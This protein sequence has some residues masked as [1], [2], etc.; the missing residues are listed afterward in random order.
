MRPYPP[1]DNNINKAA[2][3]I[4]SGGIV[5]FP[6]E[7]V[8][9]LGANALNATAVVKIFEAKERPFFDPLI[10]HIAEKDV[11]TELITELDPLSEQL[12]DTFW[13]G[14]LTLVF[15]KNDIVPDITTSGLETVAVRMPKNDVAISL[16]KASHS[17]IAAPSANKFSALSPTNAEHVIFQLGNKV[18]MVLDGG[19]CKVGVESTILKVNNGIIYLLRPGG[20]SV[21]EIEAKTN[22]KVES[23]IAENNDKT[24]V[25][26]QLPFHYSPSTPIKILDTN[27]ID[28][29]NKNVVYLLFTDTLPTIPTEKKA[30]LSPTGNLQEA[31]ANLFSHL[32]M[33]DKKNA[34][35]IIAEPVPEEGLGR[36]IMDRLHKATKKHSN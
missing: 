12:I 34:D 19:P 9:G 33:L 2:E 14:P 3:I 25:P 31:A 21:E 11:L 5:S 20:I 15:S 28:P 18:D 13:P 16:L 30:I 1:T 24:E 7:T 8:Y 26:G 29:G 27:A 10:V 36:A 35:I 4:N 23:S 17:P 32:H 22:H 6:T